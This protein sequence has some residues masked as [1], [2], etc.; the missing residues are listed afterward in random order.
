MSIIDNNASPMSDPVE[1][2]S[3]RRFVNKEA[4]AANLTI[5]ELVMEDGSALRLHTHP[6]RQRPSSCWTAASRW[7]WE[8][9]AGKCRPATPCWRRRVCLIA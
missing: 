7:L 8:T 1:G 4:G 3:A 2:R 5:G 9:S 6:H